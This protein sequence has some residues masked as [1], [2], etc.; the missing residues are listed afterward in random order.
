MA[1]AHPDP[2]L[3]RGLLQHP[4]VKA[5]CFV[6]FTDP[7]QRGG[8]QVGVAGVVRL[9]GQDLPQLLD[10]FGWAVLAVE[11][12]G[13][14]GPRGGEPGRQLQRAAQQAFGILVAPDPPGNFG[15][16]PDRGDFERAFFQMF[17]QQKLGARNVIVVHRYRRLNQPRGV[18]AEA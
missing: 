17:A 12:Q 11:H 18:L 16:H 6:K 15:Q 10:R 14:I 3:I 5:D 1:K 13:Q 9:L 8:L 2:R 4:F 7:A